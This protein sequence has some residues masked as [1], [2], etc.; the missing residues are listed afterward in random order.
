MGSGILIGQVFYYRHAKS[1]ATKEALAKAR[2]VGLTAISVGVPLAVLGGLANFLF[3]RHLEG[4]II[5]FAICIFLVGII[6]L[7]LVTSALCTE[8]DG[9]K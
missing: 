8:T 3:M 9:A 1:I 5:G 7:G 2:K 6:S 4:V